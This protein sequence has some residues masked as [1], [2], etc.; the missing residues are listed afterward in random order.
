MRAIVGSLLLCLAAQAADPSPFHALETRVGARLGVVAVDTGSG[1]R[2]DHRGGERFALCSTFKLLLAAQ[3]L[4]RVDRGQERLDRL[5]AYGP[6]ELLADSPVTSREV[7]K[8]AMTVADLCAAT[9]QTSDNT[10]ANLLLGTVGGPSGL[11]RFL[12]ALGDPVTRLDR[13]EPALNTPV[14]GQDLD[15]T[16]PAAMA[17]TVGKLVL[18]PVLAEPSRRRLEQWLLGNTTGSARLKAGLPRGWR[19]ADKTGTG[20]QGATHD[21]GILYPPG[22]PPIVV[23]AYCADGKAPRA[24]LEAVLAEA[25]RLVVAEFGP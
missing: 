12:R 22:R 7:G 8:G 3:V 25:A 20:D 6:G 11:T 2:I 18:G 19:I 17:E 15:T 9:L 4:Q 21:I 10:A 13:I 23:T 14:P 5:I 16:T 1:R 24:A